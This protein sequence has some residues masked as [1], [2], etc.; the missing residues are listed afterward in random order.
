MAIDVKE[1]ERYI[2]Y[3]VLKE[4]NNFKRGFQEN[5]EKKVSQNPQYCRR[6]K[7]KKEGKANTMHQMQK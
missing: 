4:V 2:F 6:Y 7:H 3:S 5:D 1:Y